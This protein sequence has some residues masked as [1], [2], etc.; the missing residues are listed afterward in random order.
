MDTVGL[1]SSCVLPPPL[2]HSCLCHFILLVRIECRDSGNSLFLWT[3]PR[4]CCVSLF[5]KLDIILRIASKSVSQPGTVLGPGPS[6][7][8]SFF[9]V[10]FMAFFGKK[11]CYIFFLCRGLE[12]GQ[13]KAREGKTPKIR[14]EFVLAPVSAYLEPVTPCYPTSHWRIG[15]EEGWPQWGKGCSG[16]LHSSRRVESNPPK[17]IELNSSGLL[18]FSGSHL[19]NIFW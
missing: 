13:C 17:K 18:T 15:R 19:V 5:F 11:R 4:W 1:W 6:A 8:G 9:L 3:G 12:L 7:E 10:A 2:F 14:M 16:H